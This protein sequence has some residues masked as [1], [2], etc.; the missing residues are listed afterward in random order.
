VASFSFIPNLNG[1]LFFLPA[2]LISAIAFSSPQSQV[3]GDILRFLS[4]QLIGI[5]FVL[6]AGGMMENSPITLENNQGVKSIILVFGI[7]FLFIFSIFP[8][9]T[10]IVKISEDAHPYTV[11][12]IVL[13]LYGGYAIHFSSLLNE[14]QWMMEFFDVTGG[15]LFAGT[16]MVISGGIFA[17][18]ETNLGRMLGYAIVMELGYVLLAIS[19]NETILTSGWIIP[20]MFSYLIW[21]LGL[22]GLKTGSSDLSFGSIRGFARIFPFT[23][24]SILFAHL[25]VT[26]MP[27]LAGFPAIINLWSALAKISSSTTLLCLLG[28]TGLMIGGVRSLA[29]LIINLSDSIPS[30]EENPIQKTLLGIGIVLLFLF[31]LFPNW[32]Y[33]FFVNLLT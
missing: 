26:G 27:L 11:S 8:L 14:Y 9:F 10:W 20:R 16:I 31:G 13:M 32:V 25:S 28:S 19:I 17:A 21:G 23:S 22:A 15:I 1:I 3:S 30:Q 5:A 7:G 18:F 24:T 2:I 4:Y 6:F 29:E 33:G 12:Y